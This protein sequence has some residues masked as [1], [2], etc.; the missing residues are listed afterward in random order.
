M[1]V[2]VVSY[3]LE[4]R[5]WFLTIRNEIW[6]QVSDLVLDIVH[7]GS[8]SIEGLSA[9]PIIDMDIVVDDMSN[10]D[11]VKKRLARLGYEHE[12]DLGITGR[13]SFK[14]DY[15]HKY[16]HNLYLCP[17]DSLAYKNHLMLKKHMTENPEDRQRY[18]DLKL[19]LAETSESKDIY[20]KAK[21]TLILEFL[22]KQGMSENELESIRQD[23]L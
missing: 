7:V 21:T 11:E 22:E 9:K 10:F 12:G 8:T 13:E 1:S 2:E 16:N 23:N 3:N 17:K 6:P 18:S 19:G 5:N 15:V 4:W 14:L 20:W